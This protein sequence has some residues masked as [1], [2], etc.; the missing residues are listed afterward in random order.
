LPVTAF[1][2]AAAPQRLR[3]LQLPER[4]PVIGV[5]ARQADLELLAAAPTGYL[6]TTHFDTRRFPPPAWAI[7]AFSVAAHQGALA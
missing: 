7:E 6:D 3:R 2:L 5:S 1:P 4:A